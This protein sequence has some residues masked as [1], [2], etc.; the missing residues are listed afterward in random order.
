MRLG[1][2]AGGPAAA[3]LALA[4]AHPDA[5]APAEVGQ[6]A[7]VQPLDGGID[8]AHGHFLAFADEGLVQRIGRLDAGRARPEAPDG[9]LLPGGGVLPDLLGH[10]AETLSAGAGKG[11]V[12]CLAGLV[13]G[14]FLA[15]EVRGHLRHQTVGHELAA[16][17]GD[18]ALHAV[19]RFVVQAHD[20][21]ADVAA[22]GVVVGAHERTDAGVSP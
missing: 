18:E 6:A 20:A 8:L 19:A 15:D 1:Q 10:L 16:G 14:Q 12:G 21:A 17:D 11:S 3:E 7:H 13:D 22:G 5:G 4:G 2:Q 9:R